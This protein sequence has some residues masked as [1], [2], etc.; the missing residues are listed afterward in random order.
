MTNMKHVLI[1][2]SLL[3][4]FTMVGYAQGCSDAGFCTV[5][6]FKPQS[7][8]SMRALKEELSLGAF[9]GSADNSITV[10]GSYLAYKWQLTKKLGFDVKLTSL[11]Q[12][13]NG[14]STAGLSDV[15]LNTNYRASEQ[16]QFTLGS[17][18]PFPDGVTTNSKANY[19]M[20]YQTSLGSYDLLLGVAYALNKLQLVVALQQPLVHN[21]NQFL[22]STFPSDDVLS[23]FQSTNKFKR[24]GDVLLRMA[25]PI[26]LTHKL[27]IT[28]SILPIYHL[29]NDTY[30]D[31]FNN[32]Q[33]I[34]GSQGL[35]LNGNLY[36]DYEINRAN[37]IQLNMGMP[38]MVR[39]ARPDGLTRSFIANLEYKMRF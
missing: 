30:T 21:E 14:I 19:P 28:P 39:D 17:K 27:L 1:T 22:A 7:S 20:D 11:A 16:L 12:N 25:Y 4:L 38:F 8:D 33:E 9:W 34:A 24:S 18:I 36:L 15:Y 5:N 26:T 23:T 32:E 3:A 6:G 37:S 31:A 13:G 35:T 10:Y 29:A 2:L